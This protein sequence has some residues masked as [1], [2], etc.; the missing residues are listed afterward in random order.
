MRVPLKGRIMSIIY[1]TIASL[2]FWGAIEAFGETW[3]DGCNYCTGDPNG[4]YRC[5][6]MYCQDPVRLCAV[7]NGCDPGIIYPIGPYIKE[8]E[9]KITW[10]NDECR[11]ERD[12]NA[13]RRYKEEKIWDNYTG[14]SSFIL[15][16]SIPDCYYMAI[17]IGNK[18]FEFGID[19]KGIVRAREFE[20]E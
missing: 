12:E 8:T 16:V 19:E 20:G 3:E 5:T 18:Q 4:I 10:M 9:P 13:E 2:I 15:S 1:L 11:K 14:E 7:Q 6:T 17:N